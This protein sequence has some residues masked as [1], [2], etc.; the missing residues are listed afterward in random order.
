MKT[1]TSW[2]KEF[3]KRE[4]NFF[5]GTSNFPNELYPAQDRFFSKLQ[6]LDEKTINIFNLLHEINEKEISKSE[7][8]GEIEEK[9]ILH[10]IFKEIF[11]LVIDIFDEHRLFAKNSFFRLCPNLFDMDDERKN[12]SGKDIHSHQGSLFYN[13]MYNACFFSTLFSFVNATKRIKGLSIQKTLEKYYR[14]KRDTGVIFQPAIDDREKGNIR[15]MKKRLFSKNGSF[16]TRPEWS[17]IPFD[18]GFELTLIYELRFFDF[19][20]KE[21]DNR[22]LVD[23][24]LARVYK[25]LGN[26]YNDIEKA[27]TQP[28]ENIFLEVPEDASKR[29]LSKIKKIEYANYLELCKYI[30]SKLLDD[31]QFYGINLYRFEKSFGLYTTTNAVSFLLNCSDEEI[32]N[33]FLENLFV[34]RDIPFPKLSECLSI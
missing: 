33:I 12:I 8:A 9:M 3:I 32:V 14:P 20:K 34:L 18:S 27:L 19:L 26:L 10:V 28:H 23:E 15:Q 22:K 5:G 21:F 31:N 16:N 30:S 24:K 2:L 7:F 17:S 25:R 4:D 13:H 29:F 6:E 1:T 11:D